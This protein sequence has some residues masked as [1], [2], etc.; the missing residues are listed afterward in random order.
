LV[1]WLEGYLESVQGTGRCLTNALT[2]KYELRK[3]QNLLSRYNVFMRQAT[4]S[5]DIGAFA[6]KEVIQ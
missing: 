1:S 5:V 4:S 2:G 3:P 6:E